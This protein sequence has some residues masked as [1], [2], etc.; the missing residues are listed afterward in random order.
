MTKTTVERAPWGPRARLVAAGLL[1]ALAGAASSCAS[2]L[3]YHFAPNPLD[4]PVRPDDE[5]PL[6]A[7]ALV[8]VR[9]M[10][11][12]ELPGGEGEAVV[13]RVRIRLENE[14]AEPIRLVP[15]EM[16]LVDLDLTE[17]GE[18][19]IEVDE[20]PPASFELSPG[21]SEVYDVYF[22]LPGG[23][24]A[25]E[26]ALERLCL[27]WTVVDSRGPIYVTS[28]FQ[29]IDG[30]GPSFGIGVGVIAHDDRGGEHGGGELGLALH[31]FERRQAG[32]RVD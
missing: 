1:A 4:V 21:A 20:A 11:E 14:L 32:P 2:H 25:D 13:M 3:S 26:L 22:P 27:R 15:E 23:R 8:S 29:R 17:F 5:G 7:R 16:S 12:R 6:V 28:S 19:W 10:R 31:A 24:D 9:G 18:P 30:S